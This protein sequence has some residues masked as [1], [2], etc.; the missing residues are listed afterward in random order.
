MYG[1]SGIGDVG[2][3]GIRWIC[4]DVGDIRY[5]VILYG[6]EMRYYIYRDG[7]RWD[8][9]MLESEKHVLELELELG[10][11]VSMYT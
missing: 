4:E 8:G 6:G 3:I 2:D 11:M 9:V 1:R 7:W 10:L 5:T